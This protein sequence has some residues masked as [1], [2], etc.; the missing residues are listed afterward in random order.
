MLNKNDFLKLVNQFNKADNLKNFKM[1]HFGI[2]IFKKGNEK[3]IDKYVDI[4]VDC[5]LDTVKASQL[6]NIY[7]LTLDRKA[8]K[9]MIIRYSLV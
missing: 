7:N 6:C 8:D 2:S 3:N 4:C 5:I 1:E 9:G